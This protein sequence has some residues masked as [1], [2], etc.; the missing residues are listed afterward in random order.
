MFITPLV[1]FWHQTTLSIKNRQSE[2]SLLDAEARQHKTPAQS[3]AT[4][5][6]EMDLYGLKWV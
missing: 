2:A 4:N 1:K 5:Y 6:A 3:C